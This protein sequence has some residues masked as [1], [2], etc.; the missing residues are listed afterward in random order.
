MASAISFSLATPAD[1]PALRS[2]LRNNPLPGSIRLSFEREPDYFA[3]TGIEGPFQ[4]TIVARE[5]NTGLIVGMGGRSI[6]PMVVDGVVRPVGYMSQLRVDQRY[7]WG[8]ELGRTLSQVFAFYRQLHADGRAGLYLLSVVDGN[9]A[10]QRLLSA[11]LPCYP[12]L[13]PLTR[14]HTF[15]LYVGRRRPPLALPAGL[16]LAPGAARWTEA[17]VACLQR[18]GVRHPFSPAWTASALFDPVA[19]P[20]LRPEDF[21]LA[22]TGDQV[23]GCLALWDQSAVKQTIVRGYNGALARW[24][25]LLNAGARLGGW[26]VL[27]PTDTPLRH[28]YASH[29]ALD[30]DD[31]ILFA[32]LLRAVYRQACARQHRF[33]MLGLDQR[34]PLLAVARCYPHMRYDSQIFL[35]GWGDDS[36]LPPVEDRPTGIEIATL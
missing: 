19:T 36:A 32:A 18:S 26:P 23:V 1:D 15:A 14:L 34:S 30:R 2:L 9:Q 22:V 6:R 5:E 11:G 10:A 4:Q 3:A 33:L 12:W 7:A 21:V 8:A 17:L 16:T 31:P 35:A 29:L 20:G 27:P 13:H 25:P 28:A 24:R